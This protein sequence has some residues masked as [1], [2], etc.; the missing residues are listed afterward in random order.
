M[1]DYMHTSGPNS[2]STEAFLESMKE[3]KEKVAAMPKPK[4][5]CLVLLR[6]HWELIEKD[7]ASTTHG[8]LYDPFGLPVYVVENEAERVA[9]VTE[10]VL[11]GRSV[12]TAKE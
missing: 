3:I 7:S 6:K 9:K 5:D 11:K 1:T 10:L 12:G 4:Y 8:Q 2:W